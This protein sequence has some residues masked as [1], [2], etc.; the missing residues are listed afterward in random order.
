[1]ST[2][3]TKTVIYGS[4]SLIP[5]IAKHIQKDFEKDGFEVSKDTLCTGGCDISIS[6][7]G[8]FKAVIGMKTALKVTLLPQGNN[9][10]FEAGVGIWGQQAVPTIISMLFFWPVLLT[11]LWGLVK[12]S[13]LDDRA[14]AVANEVV[15]RHYSEADT[16]AQTQYTSHNKSPLKFCTYCGTANPETEKSCISCG[17]IFVTF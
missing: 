10:S 4:P 9:I 7:G 8:L 15:N 11:Q 16:T 3:C 12:Q 2:F 5:Q 6:K 13:Q 17:K 14:L 1:M